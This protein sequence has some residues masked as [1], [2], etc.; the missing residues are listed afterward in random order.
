MLTLDSSTGLEWL[1]VSQG[2]DSYLQIM[3]DMCGQ[4]GRMS[5]RYAYAEG[6]TRHLHLG[7]C[8]EEDDPLAEALGE[9]VFVTQEEPR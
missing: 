1:D 3:E 4:V 5:G 2:M 7:F 8:G 9:G 6:W